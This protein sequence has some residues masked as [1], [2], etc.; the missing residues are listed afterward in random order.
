MMVVMVNVVLTSSVSADLEYVDFS[1]SGFLNLVDNASVNSDRLRLTQASAW[2]KGAV[3]YDQKQ[4][5]QNGFDTTFKFQ[6][7]EKDPVYNGADGFAF[8]I[9]NES[10]TAIGRFGQPGYGSYTIEETNGIPN[11]IAIEFDTYNNWNLGDPGDNHISVQS[12]GLLPNCTDHEYSYGVTSNISDLNDGNVHTARILY[13]GDLLSVFLNDLSNPC[14]S[15]N[16]D[17]A[18][19]LQLDSGTSWVGFTS[20]TG[21]G[22]EN[23][24]IIDWSFTEVPEP[25]TMFLLGLGGL[26]LRKK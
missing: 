18:N 17:M 5:V 4:N 7:T 11:S 21:S 13:S 3:W 2:N 10:S 23:H 15:V 22:Y 12:R 20:G 26:L 25:A 24:D 6:I 9:Q 8:V 1:S 19:I 14:L 16:L